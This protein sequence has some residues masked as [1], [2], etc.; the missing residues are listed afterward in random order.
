[1]K[2]LVQNREKCLGCG[3]CV[4]CCKEVFHMAADAKAEVIGE[5][6]AENEDMVTAVIESCPVNIFKLE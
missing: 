3:F 5:M 6:T 4:S 1:M 2:I